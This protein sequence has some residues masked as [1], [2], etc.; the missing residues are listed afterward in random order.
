MNAIAAS[1]SIGWCRFKKFFHMLGFKTPLAKKYTEGLDRLIEGP[2]YLA[3]DSSLV[4]AWIQLY[5]KKYIATSW[6][7]REVYAQYYLQSYTHQ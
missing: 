7:V 2:F 1:K 4:P 6:G 3:V 5:R